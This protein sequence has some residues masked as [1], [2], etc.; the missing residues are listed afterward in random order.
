MKLSSE[1]INEIRN[2]VDIVDVVSRYIS[3]TKRGKNY[4]GVCPFHEDS[5]PSLSVS[6]DKQIFSCFS[7][8]TAGNVFNFVME[9][10][11]ISFLEAVKLIADIAGISIN[12][13]TTKKINP[14]NKK[15]Y[16][17]YELAQKFYL[18]NIN[19]LFGKEAKDYLNKRGITEQMIKEFEIGLSIKKS[20]ALS[21]LLEKKDFTDEELENS[22]LI[23][24]DE[25]GK[26]DFFYNRVMFPLHDINNKVIGYSGRIY[27]GSDGA[28]YINSKEHLLFKKG[29]FLY[30]YAKAKDASRSKNVVIL[31]EGFM[32]V[33]RAYSIGVK[34]V[35][36][37]LGTAF[38]KE[39]ANLIKR[40]ANDIIICYDG[41][42]AGEKASIA[43]SNE[44]L[45]IG[46]T[47]KIV[48][49]EDNLD[50]DEYILKYGKDKFIEKINNP[51]NIMDFKLKYFKNDLDL[52]QS[53][54]K[55]KYANLILKELEK[56][57]DDILKEITLKKVSE[58]TSLEIEF[59]R[60][61][62]NKKEVK[63]Q[64]IKKEN[65]KTSGYTKAQKELIFYMLKDEEIIKIYDNSGV[66]F[67]EQQYRMLA[68][69]INSYYKHN[70]II[71]AGLFDDLDETL[72]KTL[73]I[74]LSQNLPDEHTKSQIND[75][76]RVIK[77]KNIDD[78][79]DRL[80]K[81]L[82]DETLESEKEKIGMRILELLRRKDNISE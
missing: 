63:K 73:G 69:E 44:L 32:D 9:Y 34:N 42:K 7:C 16:D 35:V 31:M 45:S 25:R 21:T 60:S 36:A 52:T 22:G 27:D 19:T 12:I 11:H 59:L 47:P 23:V 77:E 30:N 71:N 75:Y 48:R 37:T 51:L 61:K 56:I 58:E 81:K 64:V 10:E 3:L 18:N 74:V 28:K 79:V 67:P 33:I 5:D 65:T 62:L 40:L 2:S 8:H 43:C 68:N 50:P 78:E 46:I 1:Q 54:D 15:I 39:H 70:K 72:N 53:T 17:I 29:E 38:T 82:K 57:D 20:T 49:L 26:H 24:L 13:D 14:K 66:I 80:G 41:D 6:S 76:I 4:F 55:A